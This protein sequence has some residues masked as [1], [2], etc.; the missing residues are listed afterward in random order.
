MKKEDIEK[1]M[2]ALDSAGYE[3]VSLIPDD[4]GQKRPVKE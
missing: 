2:E 4:F 3:L 1:L